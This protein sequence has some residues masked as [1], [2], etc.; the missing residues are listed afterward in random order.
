ML[1]WETRLLFIFL[2]DHCNF[3]ATYRNVQT[4]GALEEKALENQ[5]TTNMNSK[6]TEMKKELDLHTCGTEF[7]H[8]IVEGMEE[9]RDCVGLQDDESFVDTD[10]I[11][12]LITKKEFVL[13]HDNHY[14]KNRKVSRETLDPR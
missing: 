4:D 1:S 11:K 14:P 8:D 7:E 3:D 5:E 2:I 10:D 6:L 12:K 9:V 13:S